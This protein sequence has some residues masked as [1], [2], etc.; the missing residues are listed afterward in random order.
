MIN[1][2]LYHAVLKQLRGNII[3]KL[4]EK[5]YRN[6]A[7]F[8]MTMRD[9]LPLSTCSSF[10]KT[11]NMLVVS[12]PLYLSNIGMFYI[13]LFPTLK[14]WQFDTIDEF[15]AELRQCW[16][17]KKKNFTIH[18]I[19]GRR[20]EISVWAPKGITLKVSVI[21]VIK[22]LVLCDWIWCYSSQNFA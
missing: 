19:H 2:E 20:S 11:N 6:T 7:Y 18:S 15:Q 3:K 12:H 9:L 16:W 4:W 1:G 8:T 13:F 5:W 21:K 17:N 14:S 10:C 22:L